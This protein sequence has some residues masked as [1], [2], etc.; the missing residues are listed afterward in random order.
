MIALAE[1]KDMHENDNPIDLPKLL[2]LCWRCYY[3]LSDVLVQ[4]QSF[5]AALETIE[6]ARR[7]QP[8]SV[9]TLCRK[10]NINFI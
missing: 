8:I 10:G 1:T 4:M 7:L 5:S 3:E 6:N 2:H 9:L